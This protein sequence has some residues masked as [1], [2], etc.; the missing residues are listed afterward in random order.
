MQLSLVRSSTCK[1]CSSA[2]LRPAASST[3][4][5]GP[6][7]SNCLEHRQLQASSADDSTRPIL[8]SF[9]HLGQGVDESDTAASL[10]ST[11]QQPSAFEQRL[12]DV[13]SA[14]SA[15]VQA[16]LDDIEQSQADA[17]AQDRIAM[18]TAILDGRLQVAA[19]LQSGDAAAAGLAAAAPAA[20]QQQLLPPPLA[21]TG[22]VPPA[23]SIRRGSSIAT[24]AAEHQQRPHRELG[25][26]P[27]RDEHA[28]SG[29]SIA[30][31]GVRVRLRSVTSCR[32]HFYRRPN[33]WTKFNSRVTP[34]KLKYRMLY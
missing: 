13:L 34:T 29:L 22:D 6:Q 14:H 12:L 25:W 10:Q 18:E 8:M 15:Q 17:R 7:D 24:E 4:R 32:S 3:R 33:R 16:R 27:A 19:Q 23:V 11:E 31:P 20:L 28:V 26:L 30:K 5:A 1:A 2:R 21:L 9:R